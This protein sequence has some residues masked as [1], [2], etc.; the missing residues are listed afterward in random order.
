V[1]LTGDPALIEARI[2]AR[3]G[4]YAGSDLLPSQLQTLEPPHGAVT[5]DVGGTPEQTARLAL[6]GLRLGRGIR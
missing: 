5:V 2:D 3:H 6:I 1:W 4:H